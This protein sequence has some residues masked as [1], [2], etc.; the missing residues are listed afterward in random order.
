MQ[1]RRHLLTV[2]L[3][4]GLS[5]F[6]GVG[7][8]Q[9][10]ASP[11]LAHSR[12]TRL[13]ITSREPAF[14]G[15][16]FGA[17]GAYE[18]LLGTATAVADPSAPAR[19]RNRG[20]RERPAQCGRAGR[21]HLRGRHS[22]AGRHHQGQ[23]RP[24]VRDQQPRPQHR[25]RLLPRGGAGLRGRERRQRIPHEPGL[26]VRIERLAARRA[27]RRRPASGAGDPAARHGRRPD[28]H[29]RLDGGVAGPGQRRFRA[30]DLSRGD[31]RRDRR[32]ADASPAPE[33]CAPD[34]SGRPLALRR[35]HD[36]RGH[37]PRGN[38]RGNHLRVRVRGPG[39]DRSRPGLQRHARSRVVRALPSRRRS[40]RRQPA[41]RGRHAGARPRGGRRFLAERPDGQG[42]RLPGLQR[43]S[44]RGGASSTA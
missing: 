39:S 33:R 16:S 42:L 36:G 31:A 10:S 18:I 32:D 7:E 2:V 15:R 5:G 35:R 43:G 28:D 26:H 41:L 34:G 9:E 23:R 6:Q 1:F 17:V 11:A 3:G 21:I 4:I 44:R 25:P 19:R 38:R 12:V 13:D 29:R 27:G 20:S 8:A 40:G 22:Q 30:A 24:G 37:A 14:G